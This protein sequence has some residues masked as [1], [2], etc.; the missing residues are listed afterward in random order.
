MPLYV[1]KCT[2][3]GHT[4]ELIRSVADR[5]KEALCEECSNVAERVMVFTKNRDWF[6]P[7]VQE[8]FGET[9][10]FVESKRHYKKLCKQYGVT[11][12]CLL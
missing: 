4:Q 2:G 11:A 5:D 1:Y 8:D 12:R 6:R 9:P 7:F 3:C 10:V